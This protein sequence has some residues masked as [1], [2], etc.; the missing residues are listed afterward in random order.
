M[1]S[2]V[3]ASGRILVDLYTCYTLVKRNTTVNTATGVLFIS[4]VSSDT[5]FPCDLRGW[6]IVCCIKPSCGWQGMLCPCFPPSLPCAVIHATTHA[7]CHNSRQSPFLHYSNTQQRYT[8]I[9]NTSILQYPMLQYSS[10]HRLAYSKVPYANAQ[11]PKY[12]NTQQPH[13]KIFQYRIALPQY[14]QYPT[15]YPRT[16]SDQL[17]G[18]L[19]ASPGALW[20]L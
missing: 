14:P 19:I 17:S 3:F 2:P 16:C 9:P 7:K 20:P 1:L 15:S 11:V 10:T 6:R 4:T 13:T 12:S 8:P 5:K 18:C